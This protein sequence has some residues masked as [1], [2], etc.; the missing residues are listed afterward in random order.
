MVESMLGHIDLVDVRYLIALGDAGGILPP[1]QDVPPVARISQ[2]DLWKLRGWDRVQSLPVL[3]ISS[4]WLDRH[5]PD[6]HGAILRRILPILRAVREQ[7][8][9][10]SRHGTVGVFWDYV[11]LP[12]TGPD[13]CYGATVEEVERY[14]AALPDMAGLYA[15]P[16]TIVLAVRTDIPAGDYTWCEK[17]RPYLKRGWC[18]FE[19]RLASIVKHRKCLWD[20]QCRTKSAAA[21]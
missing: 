2:A 1:W 5:H 21:T 10:Y 13:N 11:S 16:Y 7:A 14:H 18:R 17:K 20:T 12:Q 3:V 19:L 9:R 6:S 8:E 15:H 4:P